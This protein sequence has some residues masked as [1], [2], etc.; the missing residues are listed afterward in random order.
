[1][2]RP[3]MIEQDLSAPSA[4]YALL[5]I[6]TSILLSISGCLSTLQPSFLQQDDTQLVNYALASYGTK[7]S[8]S[9]EKPG[10][11]AKTLNNGLTSSGLWDAGEGWAASSNGFPGRGQNAFGNPGAASSGRQV[12]GSDARTSGGRAGSGQ[13]GNSRGRGGV[14]QSALGWAV[15]E[16]PEIKH[17]SKVIVHTLD[18]EKYPAS[19]YGAS[20]V[21]LQY[22]VENAGGLGWNNVDRHNKEIGQSDDSIK[23]ITT[24]KIV[25]RFKPV[26]TSKIRVAVLWSNDAERS[27]TSGRQRST[28]GTARLIEIEAYGFEKVTAKTAEKP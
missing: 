13:R 28:Q 18:S 15:L 5:L 11:P 17:L 10:H 2:S 16:F 22:W 12:M 21:L 19:Q 9:A 3:Q 27:R 1:M 6:L 4:P 23:N 7:V 14:E 8:V 26:K 25:F 24:G 20:H